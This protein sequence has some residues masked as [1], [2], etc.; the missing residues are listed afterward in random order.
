MQFENILNLANSIWFENHENRDVL[1]EE[2]W[3]NENLKLVGTKDNIELNPE[4]INTLKTIRTTTLQAFDGQKLYGDIEF[5]NSCLSKAPSYKE[6]QIVEGQ[7]IS[8]SVSNAPVQ[9]KLVAQLISALIESIENGL[10]Q[11]VR[12]CGVNDCQFYFLDKSKNQNKK[13][14][15]TKC[16]NVAKVRRFREKNKA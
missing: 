12:R 8:K 10:I 5:I 1:S 4:F 3:V 16:N 14:C 15:S 9:D 7:I 13:Y 11:K 6:V 2:T